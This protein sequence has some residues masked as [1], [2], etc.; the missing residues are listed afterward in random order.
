MCLELRILIKS[1]T[2]HNPDPNYYNVGKY[3]WLENTVND[4]QKDIQGH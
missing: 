2:V 4:R 1:Q 3:K